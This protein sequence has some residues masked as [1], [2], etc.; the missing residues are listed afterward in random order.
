M[1][2]LKCNSRK[3]VAQVSNRRLYA[4]DEQSKLFTIRPLT[5]SGSS[6]P[7]TTFAAEEAFIMF[8]RLSNVSSNQSL[9]VVPQMH[10]EFAF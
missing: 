6:L 9:W 8:W 4:Y 10:M 7:E 2:L 5:L 3:S 1:D